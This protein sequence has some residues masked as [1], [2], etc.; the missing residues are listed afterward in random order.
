MNLIE[1]LNAAFD[2]NDRSTISYIGPIFDMVRSVK[3]VR[4]RLRYMRDYLSLNS[5]RLIKT[6]WKDCCH[7]PTTYRKSY[8][9]RP[10]PFSSHL[11]KSMQIWNHSVALLYD[12]KNPM[13][14]ILLTDVCAAK[15]L[16][17]IGQIP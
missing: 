7:L 6:L 8:F 12:E 5:G 1:N 17:K 16:G 3:C 13:I 10:C 15:C 14:A 2:T 4:P 11:P 9:V